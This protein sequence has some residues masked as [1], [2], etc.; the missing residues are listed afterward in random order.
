MGIGFS[1]FLIAVGAILAW[2][3]NYTLTGIDISVVGAILMV[4]GLVGLVLSVL[5]WESFSPFADRSPFR[6]RFVTVTSDPSPHTTV[7]REE[8]RRD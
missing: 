5:F 1:L 2:A 8:V 4:I 3:V 7:V 6:R